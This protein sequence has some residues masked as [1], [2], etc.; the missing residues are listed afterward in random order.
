MDDLVKHCW[1]S[2]TS[3]F[4]N[5]S[6]IWTNFTKKGHV[7]FYGE[8]S[9]SYS[10]FNYNGKGFLVQN[11]DYYWNHFDITSLVDIGHTSGRYPSC[12]GPRP[13][14]KVLIKSVEK[15]I[16]TFET[17]KFFLFYWQVSLAHSHVDVPTLGDEDY[18]KH[19]KF[20]KNSGTLNCSLLIFMSDHGYR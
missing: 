1:P 10:I 2:Y 5:C 16:K 11:V 4:D 17:K 7:T 8:E 15:F 19:L 18:V 3:R 20:L 9:A 6:M 14:Y 12:L 13:M